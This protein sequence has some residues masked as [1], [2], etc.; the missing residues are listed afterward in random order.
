MSNQPEP[1][2][3][4][5]D[6][7]QVRL[8]ALQWGDPEAPLALCLHGFPDSA[9]T[10]RFLGPD[11]ARAGY[12]AVAP[13]TRGYAPSGLPNDNL[14]SVTALAGD[15]SSIR[16]QLHPSGPAVAIG[17]DWGGITAQAL[18]AV[19][20]SDFDRCVSLAI[21]S[22]WS[23]V[24]QA[25]V[26]TRDAVLPLLAQLG[27]SW[28]IGFNQLPALPER[29]SHPLIRHLWRSWSP[30]YDATE[31][32]IGALATLATP[33]HQKAVFNYYRALRRVRGDEAW[34]RQ[35]VVP[36]KYLHGATDGC[37]SPAL[38]RLTGSVEIPNAGHFLHLER[39]RTVNAEVLAFLA[40]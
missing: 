5:L 2:K 29:V 32:L 21:P 15:A 33:A 30:G 19:P 12:H 11:L 23:L 26:H 37:F 20:E 22:L 27:R 39:P 17:H 4:T 40:G 7:P 10:W 28:Y 31:D 36:V 1:R 8:T 35:P 9:N 18:A 3:I 24:D 34:L 16:R 13:F 25:Q 14:F 6:L 38:S